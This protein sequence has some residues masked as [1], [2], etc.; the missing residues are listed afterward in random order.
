MSLYTMDQRSQELDADSKKGSWTPEEDRMMAQLI[1][2]HGTRS[3]SLISEGMPGRSGKSCRLRWCNQLNPEV[4]KDP[5]SE[6]E[7]AVIM[8]AHKQYGNKW[9]TISRLLRGRTDNAIKNHWN[10]TLKRKCCN[11]NLFNKY[12]SEMVTLKEL[13]DMPPSPPPL[14]S[15][16][17]TP[18]PPPHAHAHATPKQAR[19]PSPGFWPHKQPGLSTLGKRGLN[20]AVRITVQTQA[21]RVTVQTQAVRIAVQPPSRDTDKNE[22]K[23]VILVACDIETT[24]GNPFQISPF[25][26]SSPGKTSIMQELPLRQTGGRSKIEEL[27]ALNPEVR[28]CLVEVARLCCSMARRQAPEAGNVEAAGTA[29]AQVASRPQLQSYKALD[30]PL[31]QSQFHDLVSSAQA[32]QQQ[33]AQAQLQDLVSSAQAQAQAQAHQQ[34]QA[35]LHDLVTNAQA[36]QQREWE[37]EQ[38]QSHSQLHDLVTSAQA[39]AQLQG[40]GQFHALA[41]SLA[42][43]KLPPTMLQLSSP[44]ARAASQQPVPLHRSVSSSIS[45]LISMP[46]RVIMETSAG[47][48]PSGMYTTHTGMGGHGLAPAHP[49][50]SHSYDM[51]KP[52]RTDPG[53]YNFTVF[54]NPPGYGPGPNEDSWTHNSHH[55][56]DPASMS[57]ALVGGIPQ[58][59][60]VHSAVAQ[61]G[62]QSQDILSQLVQGHGLRLAGNQ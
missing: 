56:Y 38:A 13:L 55:H 59:H 24:Y 42:P 35:H 49:L 29:A 16:S 20:D 6:W 60:S 10:A 22:A 8:E 34:A 30:A 11:G 52:A 57:Q 17:P 53:I 48:Q 31:L 41:S 44:Q 61:I 19:T 51:A 39:Q 58:A 12:L 33:Q 27:D 47:G 62:N 45:S 3:W 32:Q 40:Q 50:S 46:S 15:P 37:R 5:F 9:A 4:R 21:V 28:N 18:T 26:E 2:L 54:K 25:P 14:L 1:A 7:D 36:Q 23:N 43:Q